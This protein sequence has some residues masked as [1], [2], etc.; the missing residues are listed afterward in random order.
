MKSIRNT[1]LIWLSA[2]LALGIVLVAGLLYLQAR[3]EANRL[4]DYQLQQIAAAVPSEFFGYVVS[5]RAD[6]VIQ[7]GALRVDPVTH[8][9]LLNGESVSLSAREFTLLQAFLDR[10]GVV[11][12]IPQLE[13][14]MYGW[15]DEVGSNTVEVYIHALRKKLGADVIRNV[16]GVGYMAP[17]LS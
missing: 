6:P 12:S 3:E 14:K 17:K 10:P 9:V 15:Q 8:E 7:Y 4:F 2:G 16:R 13:E 11:M 1:L 5:G